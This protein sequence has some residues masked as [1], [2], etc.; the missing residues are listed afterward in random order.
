MKINLKFL[1]I[2]FISFL[3]TACNIDEIP[4]EIPNDTR[5]WFTIDKNNIGVVNKLKNPNKPIMTRTLL[6]AS[7]PL[8]DKTIYI[9]AMDNEIKNRPNPFNLCL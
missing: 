3:Y 6:P 4:P 1:Q 8:K 7:A 5:G 2:F 9:N